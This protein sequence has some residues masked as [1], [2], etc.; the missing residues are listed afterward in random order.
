MPDDEWH[1]NAAW[2]RRLA[3]ISLVFVA[4]QG[5]VGL[6]QGWAAGS[7]ALIAW[8]LGA[9]PEGLAGAVVI[10]RFTG[11]RMLSDTAE[12]RAQIVVAVSF[13]LMAPYIV[14]ESLRHLFVRHHAESTVIGIAL[15]AIALLMMPVLG[16][17][18]RRLGTRLA[19]AA[20][21]GEGA[22]SYLC[23][24]QAAAVLAGLAVTANWSGGWWLDP[25]VGLA[26]AAIAVWQGFRSWRG[27]DCGC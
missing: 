3:S 16:R 20:T 18:Q 1:V 10:W 7:V 9:V 17:A 21:A 13:W 5:A 22:Q 6:W 27:D 26:V 8:A 23:A 4:L 19:S 24:I 25:V 2:A 11:A 14:A 15:A 12:R